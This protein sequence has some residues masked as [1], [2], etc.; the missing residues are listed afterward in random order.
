M[1]TRLALG[2]ARRGVTVVF[3]VFGAL[4]ATWVS[5]IPL[6]K[7]ELDLSAAELSLALL[8]SP[9]G[10]LIAVQLVSTLVGRW[11]SGVVTRWAVPA[12]SV[13]MVLPAFAWS[14]GSLAAS[15]LVFGL[16][17][18]TLDT[19]MNTQA[20]AIERACRKPIMSGIHGMFSVGMLFGAVVGAGAAHADVD[21]RLHF[22]VAAACLAAL[23]IWAAG[24]L[25]GPEA[26]LPVQ[27][28]D[29][30]GAEGG[31]RPRLADHPYLWVIGAIALCSFF[32]EGAVDDWSGVYLHEAQG[33]S[34]AVAPL[35]TAACSIGMAVGR[36][37][38]DAVIARHGR[39]ATL[40]R[41]SLVA[42]AGMT[43]AVVAPT[44]AVAIAGY[45]I[46]GLGV[47]TIVPI[48][49]TLAG[50][51][52][53]VAP[54]W[55]VSRVT[56]IGY[57]G[58]FGS[59]PVIGLIAEATSLAT[60]LIVPAVLLALVAPLSRVARREQRAGGYASSEIAS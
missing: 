27:S 46:L 4:A 47:A 58:L 9:V 24:A 10:L 43:V 53:G 34:F 59:P 56:V 23:G 5:R 19:A 49:L 51:T 55:A 45:G 14:L 54:V 41:S 1:E 21:P 35:G 30:D 26:D 33:A 39:Q 13:A 44:P 7:D 32:A 60:A 31:A 40:W 3:F 17:M 22:V 20:V 11:T 8:A 15:L 25:L 6:I 42:A 38:G 12:A 57:A 50:T 18:G 2:S 28:A 48:A 52:S 37:C 29:A 36:F 16:T